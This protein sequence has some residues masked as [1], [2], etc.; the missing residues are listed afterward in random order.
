VPRKQGR[1]TVRICRP[2]H[3]R[4]PRR[5]AVQHPITTRPT[6]APS[7]IYPDPPPKASPQLT[8]RPS[9]GRHVPRDR[10]RRPNPKPSNP[11]IHSPKIEKVSMISRPSANSVRPSSA[12][13]S[14]CA[15]RSQIAKG[16][17]R[18]ACFR[19]MPNSRWPFRGSQPPDPALSVAYLL[20][21]RAC[22][23]SPRLVRAREQAPPVKNVV[24]TSS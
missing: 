5:P 2:R 10:H 17:L 22:E 11:P 13:P 21:R 14:H 23:A 6:I 1:D 15:S 3:P 18:K 24:I 16:G 7:T 9:P 8:T 20:C 12:R 19:P 4:R